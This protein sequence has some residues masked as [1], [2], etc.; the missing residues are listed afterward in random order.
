MKIA[1]LD[2]HS[3]ISGDMMLGALVDAGVSLDRL[4]EALDKR[5]KQWEELLGQF[6]QLRRDTEAEKVNAAVL[7][8]A[9]RIEALAEQEDWIRSLEERVLELFPEDRVPLGMPGDDVERPHGLGGLQEYR[10]RSPL[11]R[12]AGRDAAGVRGGV[13]RLPA[14]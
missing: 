4:N 14:R 2:C 6:Q 5:Q 9:P 3:G 12:H 13:P 1:Y 11:T 8:Q 10:S 7:R